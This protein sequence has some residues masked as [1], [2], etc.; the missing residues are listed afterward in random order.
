M[1]CHAL[2]QGVFPTQGL[3]PVSYIA[4]R[5]FTTWGT[6][7]AHIVGPLVLDLS[8]PTRWTGGGGAIPLYL[9][10]TTLLLVPSAPPGKSHWNTPSRICPQN[11]LSTVNCRPWT[12]QANQDNSSAEVPVT[13]RIWDQ[14]C[15]SGSAFTQSLCYSYRWKT[16]ELEDVHFLSYSYKGLPLPVLREDD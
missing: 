2:L 9:H 10:N 1:G 16:L 3:N 14:R 11:W 12:D 8:C 15:G 4:G 13:R 5:F 7:E 6:R